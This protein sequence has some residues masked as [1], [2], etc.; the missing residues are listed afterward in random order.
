[1]GFFSWKC[2]K[3]DKPVMS[4]YAVDNTPWDF[5]SKVVVVFK[6]GDKLSGTYDG[7]GNVG[8]CNILDFDE[9]KWRMV[10][11]R[12]YAGETFEQLPRNKYDQG[13]G[14]FYDDSDLERIFRNQNKGA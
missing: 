6:D 3:S 5:A 8:E 9:Q 2:A 1:M 4:S 13:Q 10:I 12:Y 14:F 11:Q 7:Y